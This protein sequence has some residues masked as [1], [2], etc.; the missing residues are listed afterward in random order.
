MLAGLGALGFAP[1]LA[2]A[3]PSLDLAEF[4]ITPDL[5]T[6]QSPAMQAA[7]DAAA[8]RGLVLALPAGTVHV[9]DLALP[10]GL[11]I[12]G[13]AGRSV[14][15][16]WQDG[17]IATAGTVDSLT[18]TGVSFDGGIT[19][20]PE[21]RG[22]LEI[23]ASTAITLD[24][25][26]FIGGQAIGLST[27]QSA[28]TVR[29]CVF[30]GHADAAIHSIDSLGLL[31]TGNRIAD[32]GNAGIRIWRSNS[33]PD[34]SIVSEN[35]IAFIKADAGGNGQNG[36]GINVFKA[37]E[38]IVA[39]NHISD[40]AFTAI[41]LNATNNSQVIGNNCLA[42]GE[43]AIFSE[44][45]FSGSVIANNIV[46]GAAGGISMTNFN[47]G[48]QLAVCTG[49]IVRNILPRSLVNPDTTPF[50]IAAE[51]DAAVTGNTISKVPGPAINAGYGPY[52]R[53]VLI[54][55]NVLTDILIGVAVSVAEGAGTAQVSNNLIA[56]ATHAVVGMAW[57]EMV[58]SDLVA[59]AAN[60]PQLR[61]SGN[62]VGG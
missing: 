10:S 34:G 53:N 38:V 17:I 36:N 60:Y 7:L 35:R 16:T 27:T 62:S 20:A 58:D 32:C 30:D 21:G 5:G 50:G 18:I 31:I 14:L 42:S 2:Q 47:E 43:V 37:D 23:V 48:G 22:L 57:T 25:C 49:N 24:N 61:I 12:E 6:D 15:A 51:A 54:T 52:L 59:N 29:N 45:G 40:C 9:R 55:D 3:Q 13:I 41:R 33:G 8:Q 28:I 56:G 46:D 44:F 4:G 39:N 19:G 1:T 26:R 11:T